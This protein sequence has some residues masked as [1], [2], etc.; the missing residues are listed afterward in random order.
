MTQPHRHHR[1]GASF[2]ALMLVT[3]LASGCT[4]GD[5]RYEVT[6]AMGVVQ[7]A[8][9]VKARNIMLLADE[10]GKGLL[11]GS[12]FAS[13]AVELQGVAVAGEQTD[14]SYAEAVNV[15][16]TGELGTQEAFR[17]GGQDSIV[18]GTELR[19]GMLATVLMQFS[20]GTTLTL[21]TPVVSSDDPAYQ[22][23]WEQAQ[24]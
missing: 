20:D 11:M 8:G 18:E 24:A 17:F 14:G 21:N 2:A 4:A 3:G 1:F 7:D 23:A 12:L 9:P 13:E 6:P 15:E 16:V 19:A 10:S 22:A 5:W